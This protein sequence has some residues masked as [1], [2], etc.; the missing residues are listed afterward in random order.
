MTAKEALTLIKEG[1]IKPISSESSLHVHGEEYVI[2]GHLVKCFWGIESDID[3]PLV[4][5]YNIDTEFESDYKLTQDGM[6]YLK[7]LPDH[8]FNKMC[9]HKAKIRNEKSLPESFKNIISD[10]KSDWLEQATWRLENKEWLDYSRKIALQILSKKHK[11]KY[12]FEQLSEVLSLPVDTVKLMVKG[13]YNFSIKELNTLI[14]KLH[15]ELP[16]V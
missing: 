9:E 10:Q 16:S 3:N 6:G 7:I 13:K 5:I 4:E 15:I 12:S 11:E 1:D 8:I 14:N 2:D